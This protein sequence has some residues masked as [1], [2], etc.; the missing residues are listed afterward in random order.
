MRRIGKVQEKC[1]NAEQEAPFEGCASIQASRAWYIE[2]KTLRRKSNK[3]RSPKNG[4]GTRKERA[5]E[6]RLGLSIL[7]T[8][9]K[10]PPRREAKKERRNMLFR[11]DKSRW[12]KSSA[13]QSSRWLDKMSALCSNKTSTLKF[14][15]AF[16]RKVI[17]AKPGKTGIS[18]VMIS[19]GRLWIGLL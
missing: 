19:P 12:R 14:T 13:M 9:K 3:R 16:T 7:I 18:R 2:L 5:P 1:R 4:F 8:L 11:R 15:D 10:P 17:G 6:K